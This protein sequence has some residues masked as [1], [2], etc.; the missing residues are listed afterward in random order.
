[1]SPRRSLGCGPGV[2]FVTGAV[3]DVDGGY[4]L[5]VADLID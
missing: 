3:I 4:R 2:R 1:M 5:G